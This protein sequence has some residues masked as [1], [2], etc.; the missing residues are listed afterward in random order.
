MQAQEWNYDIIIFCHMNNR[1]YV[2]VWHLTACL[3]L[4]TKR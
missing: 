2:W 1:V 3:N 4:K